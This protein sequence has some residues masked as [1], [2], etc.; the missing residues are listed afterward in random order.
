MRRSSFIAL[1]GVSVTLGVLF[2]LDLHVHRTSSQAD[3]SSYLAATQALDE[4]LATSTQ[5][6]D[7]IAS[8]SKQ[9][10][11]LIE[12]SSHNAT[13]KTALITELRQQSEI[14][15]LTALTGPGITV[16]IN[17][18]PALP[19]IPGLRYVD[20]ATQLQMV[21]NYLDAA[22]AKGIAINGQR[23]V[24]TTAIRSILSFND[25]PGPFSGIVEINGLPVQAPYVIS[26]V[27]PVSSL[28]NM[29]TAEGLGQQFTILDQSF[30]IHQFPSAKGVQ[31]PPYD[32]ALPTSYAKEGGI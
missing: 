13:G 6:E 30:V 16:T 18:D 28:V 5:L 8:F 29:L 2:G 32:G 20:E 15:G 26:V 7:Q 23:L 12:A 21:V 27:G 11:A 22:G 3:Y 17:Y 1:L 31:L 10:Q 4:A 19:V 24:T 25:A 9:K 14:A